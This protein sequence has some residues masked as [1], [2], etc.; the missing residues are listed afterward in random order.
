MMIQLRIVVVLLLILV[1]L[2]VWA[3]KDYGLKPVEIAPGTYVLLG[4]N[5]H[6]NSRNGGNIVN[7]AFIVTD[8]GVV[9][10]DSGPSRLYGEQLRQVIG[11]VT[12]LPILKLFNTHLHPDHILGNQAFEDIPIAALAGTIEGIRDQGE[13]FNDNMYRLVGPWMVGT[14]VVVPTETVQPGILEIGGHRLQL[15]EMQGHSHADLVILDQTTGVLFAADVVFHGRTPTTPHAD[16]AHW[17][18][19]LDKFS[20]LDFKLLVPGHGGVVADT[21]AVVQTHD[22][23]QWLMTSLILAAE[24]GMTMAEVLRLDAPPSIARLAVFQEEYQRSVVH[25]FPE[26]E[27]KVLSRGR[28]VQE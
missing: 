7:T 5:A 25:L 22:Y 26:I 2:P 24:Q 15:I 23:L 16:V 4:E 1:I 27:A 21:R 13:N 8:A 28:V 20:H 10:I 19:A 6:F 17:L 12:E 11:K 9:V 14:R 3:A 18:K